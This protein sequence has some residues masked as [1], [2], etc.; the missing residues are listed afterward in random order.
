M[1]ALINSQIGKDSV[2]LFKSS[3]STGL[4]VKK[5]KNER[6]LPLKDK[7]LNFKFLDCRGL[8]IVCASHLLYL[9]QACS[10]DCNFYF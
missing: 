1:N 3:K 10:Q 5:K 2:L 6:M 9:S 8:R 4:V 7:V